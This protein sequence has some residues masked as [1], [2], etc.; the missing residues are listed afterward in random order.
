MIATNDLRAR[1]LRA[2]DMLPVVAGVLQRT[3]ELFLK[4]DDLSVAQLSSSIEQ[5]VVMAATILAIANSATYA[6]PEGSVP[7]SLTRPGSN[8]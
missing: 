7:G 1:A 2:A 6:A 8:R 5:D 4:N 3:L